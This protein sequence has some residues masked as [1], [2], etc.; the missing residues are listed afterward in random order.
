MLSQLDTES[1]GQDHSKIQMTVSIGAIIY[2]TLIITCMS[3]K[4]NSGVLLVIG[5]TRTRMPTSVK[6][7]VEPHPIRDRHN[8][9]QSERLK[10]IQSL[11]EQPTLI[12]EN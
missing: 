5:M 7:C 9:L 6:Q 11:T 10:I 4:K 3:K 2:C 8:K 12:L 1:K